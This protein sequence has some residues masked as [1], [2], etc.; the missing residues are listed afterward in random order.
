M[1]IPQ[2]ITAVRAVTA[3]ITLVLMACLLAGD[4]AGPLAALL[5][6]I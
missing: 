1:K 4:A 3:G 6:G 5:N 2:Y